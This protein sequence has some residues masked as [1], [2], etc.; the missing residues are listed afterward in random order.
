MQAGGFNFRFTVMAWLITIVLLTI[1]GQCFCECEFKE[2]IL[3]QGDRLSK[4]EEVL[5]DFERKFQQQDEKTHQQEQL[6][7][8]L[9][10]DLESEKGKV[11][12]Q[13]FRI[14]QHEKVIS[15]LQAEL[16]TEKVKMTSMILA[17]KTQLT[18]KQEIQ[19]SQPDNATLKNH[20]KHEISSNN[21][22]KSK[23]ADDVDPTLLKP[24]VDQLNQ[25]VL[26]LTSDM[27]TLQTSFAQQAQDIQS[28]RNAFTLLKDQKKNII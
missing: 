20:S 21:I 25:K 10:S 26:T 7:S 5:R 23:R 3:N 6:I 18:K 1:F 24:V 22:D 17:L 15:E 16:R 9:Q 12:K 8:T 27:Q 2:R 19:N 11:Q 4:V 14:H 28:G 13:E